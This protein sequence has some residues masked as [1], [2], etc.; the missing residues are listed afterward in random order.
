MNRFL[1]L[2][3]SLS[4]APGLSFAAEDA[5]SPDAKSADAAKRAAN[6]VVLDETGVKNLRIEGDDVAFDA[7]LLARAVNGQPVRLQWMRDDE[8]KWEPYGPAMTMKVKGA[9]AGGR[10]EQPRGRPPGL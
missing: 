9:V 5:K 4:L 3:L 7:A 10:F 2:L 6:T 1:A 8:F